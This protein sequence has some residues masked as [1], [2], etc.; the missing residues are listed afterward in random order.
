MSPEEWLVFGALAAAVVLVGVRAVALGMLS[1]LSQ[2]M[3]PVN[4]NFSQSWASSFTVIGAILGS[5]LSAKG[6]VPDHTRFLPASTY[7]AL[8]L[9]F[10]LLVVIGPF[11]YRATSSSVKTTTA[12]ATTDVQ[13]QGSAAG[14]IVAT[15]L[16]VWGV[17]GELATV[18]LLFGEIHSA[19][20]TS[21]AIL[22]PF[23]AVIGIADL[24]FAIYVWRAIGWID[25]LQKDKPM[26]TSNLTQLM[27]AAGVKPPATVVAP[28]PAWPAF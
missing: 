24:A 23:L 22:V 10:G 18:F 11:I 3:G 19:G 20:S 4:W 15:G 2:A 14:F 6:V 21:D 5:I 8:N 26:H 12:Q 1:R 17:V 16:T 9:L 25:D 13:Y 7:P 27:N 28:L